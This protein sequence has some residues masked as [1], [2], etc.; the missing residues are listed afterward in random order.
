MLDLSKPVTFEQLGKLGRS[1]F[2]AKLRD[3]LQG[4]GAMHQD[5]L[6]VVVVA[7]TQLSRDMGIKQSERDEAADFASNLAN[8]A[9]RSYGSSSPFCKQMVA[10]INRV[11]AG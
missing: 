9:M 6:K 3:Y 11:M 4:G 2:L 10:E 8:A 1:E 7:L 5:A